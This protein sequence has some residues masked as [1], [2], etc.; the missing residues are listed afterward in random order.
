MRPVTTQDIQN[1]IADLESKRYQAQTQLP[2]MTIAEA[3]NAGFED[4]K[5]LGQSKCCY[6]MLKQLEAGVTYTNALLGIM[7][8][9]VEGADDEWS[10]RGNDLKRM[11]HDG[12]R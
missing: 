7:D 6:L 8:K 1:R 3:I 4:K 5:L 9:L 12:F 10:G 2:G 11:E